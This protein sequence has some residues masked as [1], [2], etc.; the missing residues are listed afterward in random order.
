MNVSEQVAVGHTVEFVGENPTI[1]QGEVGEVLATMPG[2]AKVRFKY[3]Q[4]FTW[5]SW[6][7][8]ANLRQRE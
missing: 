7:L 5:E 8:I 1:L 6:F 3:K 2:C 4:A